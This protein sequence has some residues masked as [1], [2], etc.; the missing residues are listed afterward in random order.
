MNSNS[1]T[2]LKC[3]EK[4]TERGYHTQADSESRLCHGPDLLGPDIIIWYQLCT[5]LSNWSK[6]WQ[7]PHRS[8]QGA[9]GKCGSYHGYSVR[10]VVVVVR[11][12]SNC[13]D[14]NFLRWF[15]E[16]RSYYIAELLCAKRIK[17]SILYVQK[18]WLAGRSMNLSLRSASLH[19]LDF[20][21]IVAT[22]A[23][24]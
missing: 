6:V 23:L 15:E 13:V 7:S 17:H 14:S 2:T 20:G 16:Q 22:L 12:K 10:W 5:Q 24:S 4:L 21:N 8:Y 9:D 19:I 1:S 3:S 11:C 18:C